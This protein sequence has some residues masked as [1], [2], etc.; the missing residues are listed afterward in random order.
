MMPKIVSL[1]PSEIA[2]TPS[3]TRPVPTRLHGLSPDHAATRAAG[4]PYLRCQYGES[5]PR[6]VQ[7]SAMGGSFAARFGAVAASASGDHAFD[8]RS[9]RFMPEPSPGSIAAVAPVSREASH[10]LTRWTRSV[11]A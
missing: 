4:R 1:V 2:T 7:D 6:I 3:R 8:A 10:E 5:V 9:I 11:A